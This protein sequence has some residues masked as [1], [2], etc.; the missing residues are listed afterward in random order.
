M[1]IISQNGVIRHAV[2]VPYTPTIICKCRDNAK[3]G[4]TALRRYKIEWIYMRSTVRGPDSLELALEM[5]NDHFF[6]HLALACTCTIDL[7]DDLGL[8]R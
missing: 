8:V 6:E 2:N 1:R 4:A 3:V 7:I 5:R